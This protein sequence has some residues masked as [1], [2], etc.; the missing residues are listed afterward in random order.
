VPWFILGFL[1]LAALRSTGAIPTQAVEFASSVAA[2]LIVL[3]MAALGL[4]TDLKCVLKAGT[5]VA[6]AVTLSLIVLGGMSFCL[7]VAIYGR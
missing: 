6:A 4:S 7:V 3:S 5:Q 1:G 2:I